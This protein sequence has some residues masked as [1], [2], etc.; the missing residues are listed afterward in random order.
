[1]TLSRYFCWQIAPLLVAM[2]SVVDN[3]VVN[4]VISFN[5]SM[6]IQANV[7]NSNQH[8]FTQCPL[9]VSFFTGFISSCQFAHQQLA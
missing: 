1:M 8:L 9:P 7:V 6:I 4:V 5:E 2:T 3:S